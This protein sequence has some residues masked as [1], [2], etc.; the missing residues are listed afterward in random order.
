MVG[1]PFFVTAPSD[2]AVAN[3]TLRARTRTGTNWVGAFLLYAKGGTLPEIAA[4]LGINFGKLKAR[5]REEDWENLVRLNAS[6]ALRAPSA[7]TSPQ[8]AMVLIDSVQRIRENRE[9]SLSVTQA[10][11]EHLLRTLAA[12]QEA[13]QFLSPEDMYKLARVEAVLLASTM[14]AL[15]DDPAPLLPPNP[16]GGLEKEVKVGTAKP[17]A[18]FHI[19]LPAVASAPR[20]AKPVAGETREATEIHGRPV[21]PVL[22]PSSRSRVVLTPE[23]VED[24]VLETKAGTAFV[25][26][27]KVGEVIRSVKPP[28]PKVT[29]VPKL[30]Q[31]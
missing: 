10:L 18:H 5:A 9:K 30:F 15:G 25:D 13:G 31:S 23:R 28:A 17:E 12:Y 26:F 20:V 22:A 16:D 24:D 6:L 29:G 8:S 3:V 1:S 21:D 19:H 11:R 2:T 7:E 14:Q 4:E 27:K